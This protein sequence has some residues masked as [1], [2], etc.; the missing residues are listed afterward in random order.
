MSRK[1]SCAMSIT[2]SLS[3]L[4]IIF[5]KLDFSRADD[6]PINSVYSS[7]VG[8]AS[9]QAALKYLCELEKEEQGQLFKCL[10][11]NLDEEVKKTLKVQNKDESALRH[12]ICKSEGPALPP[13]IKADEE[14]FM[15]LIVQCLPNKEPEASTK[16]APTE[17]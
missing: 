14:T 10:L 6:G 9:E 3:V 15:Q 1:G 11:E 12:D 13:Y 16:N 4:V 17:A 8:S 7:F 5:V 2:A